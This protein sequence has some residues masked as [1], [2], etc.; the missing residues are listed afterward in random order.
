MEIGRLPFLHSL[1]ENAEKALPSDSAGSIFGLMSNCIEKADTSGDGVLSGEEISVFMS[2]GYNEVISEFQ[3]EL[4]GQEEDIITAFI[5]Q[6]KNF[7]ATMLKSSSEVQEDVTTLEGMNKETF[8]KNS[9]DA[10]NNEDSSMFWQI[11]GI[12]NAEGIFDN[13]DADKNGTLSAEEL[14]EIASLDGNKN[15][16]SLQDL[17]N[18][19][20]NKENETAIENTQE[21]VSPQQTQ[22]TQPTRNPGVSSSSSS[23]S[24]NPT[25]TGSSSGERTLEV[26]NKEISDQEALKNTTKEEAEAAIA[27][28]DELIANALAQSDLSEEF[29]EEYNSENQRLTTAINEK[30][31]EISNEKTLA[32]DFKA[33]AQSYASSISDIDSQI[34]S[35]ESALSGLDQNEDASQISEYN[36]KINNLKAK[37]E[38][39]ENAKN[40]AEE[41]ERLANE[42]IASLEQEKTNLITEK[43]NILNTLSEKYSNEKDKALA[44]KEEIAQYET[45]KKEIQTQLESTIN[46][47]DSKI[48][49]L[50]NEKAQVER[51]N[52]T[53]KVLDENKV[54]AD[55]TPIAINGDISTFTTEDWEKLGYNE[56]FGTN[57]ADNARVVGERMEAAGSQ[58]NCLGGV[59]RSFIAATG[60]SPFGAPEQGIT[61]ASR[62]ASVME[63]QENFREI[64]GISA[65]DLQYLP[66]GA[67]VVWTESTTGTSP[68]SR[69]GHISISL[70]DGNESSD[71]IDRQYRHVGENGRPRVFI[72]V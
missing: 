46:E 45:A 19:F 62:C 15:N 59:K 68:A 55:T 14:Q 4:E 27:E 31:Q 47:I 43:D 64:T 54:V 3:N 21:T 20:K 8:I 24:F 60:S 56:T 51:E 5:S 32:Q 57:L 40:E 1:K 66:A 18:F 71:S 13:I 61:V 12:D 33:E 38:E 63:E 30:D 69:Y 35:M 36:T 39:Y 6:L 67:V 53:Q 44:F 23:S 28:Q 16:I 22:T 41:N 52:E 70:G 26:I 7:I 48:Q 34:S 50:K 37:K 10:Q 17:G 11:M 65:N 25:T 58:A 72:P 49:E 29:K 9:T 42:R 2:N